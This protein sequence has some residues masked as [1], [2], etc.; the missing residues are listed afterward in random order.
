[1]KIELKPLGEQVVVITGA[2][3]GIGLVTARSAAARGAS[4]FLIARGEEAL[5]AI[6][7]QITGAG[8]KADFAVADVGVADEVEAAAAKAVSCYGR[9]DTWISDAGA[10]IYGKLLETPLDE[11]QRLFRTN[12]F[13]AV[14]SA[15]AAVPRLRMRG[16]ALITIGSIA[17]D[18]PT[19]LMGAYS[20]SK[21]AVK[22]YVESLRIEL[23]AD[24]APISVT[25]IKPS[26]IDTPIGQHAANHEHGE[27]QIPPPVYDP[28]L[29]ANAILTAAVHPTREITV[30]GFGRAQVLFGVH[31]PSLFGKLAP[32]I[33]K[34]FVDP[35]RAQPGPSALSTSRGDGHARSG[36]TH[37]LRLSLYNLVHARAALFGFAGVAAILAITLTATRR[38]RAGSEH[39]FQPLNNT[40]GHSHE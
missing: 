5:R 34:L 2:T 31:F 21:H 32:I 18:I 7:E 6:V 9:I 26:G 22:A 38:R 23:Q 36:E 3:S 19:P 16:G 28:Q 20:A 39:L 10:A 25:L 30:G 11:H 4:V 14:N 15:Q 12:Y 17:C 27:A 33:S 8:G 1:M 24:H 35:T 37:G 13:G 40:L 29:V